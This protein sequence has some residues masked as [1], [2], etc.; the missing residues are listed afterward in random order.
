MIDKDSIY[1]LRGRNT[2]SLSIVIMDTEFPLKGKVQEGL[3]ELA[4]ISDVFL[5]FDDGWGYSSEVDKMKFACLHD[6][7][8][9]I[10]VKNTSSE[11]LLKVFQ[12]TTT[13]SEAS[14]FLYY[15]IVLCSGLEKLTKGLIHTWKSY[16]TS[17]LI[18]KP[19]LDLR[20][21][22][23]KE[24]KEI[25]QLPKK[26]NVGKLKKFINKIKEIYR[27]YSSISATSNLAMFDYTNAYCTHKTNSWFIPM[28]TYVISSILE[29]FKKEENKDYIKT[30]KKV[31]PLYF[32]SSVIKRLKIDITNAD[33]GKVKI[34]GNN[35]TIEE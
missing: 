29:F 24:L 25:Y 11:T 14:N 30:F 15:T 21:L 28:K 32:L 18:N 35:L 23:P 20:R 31:N 8:G 19:I 26:E 16:K 9:W 7:L 1:L 33:L 27:K 17:N 3:D 5:L 22:E 12:Y 13:I 6:C 2:K 34:N 10:D 4:K